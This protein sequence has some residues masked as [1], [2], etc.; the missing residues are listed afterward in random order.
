MTLE[1]IDLEWP[2]EWFN[3]LRPHNV[4]QKIQPN[5][6]VK[7]KKTRIEKRAK[8]TPDQLSRVERE[9]QLRT[10]ALARVLERLAGDNLSGQE[11]AEEYIRRLYRRNCR[12]GTL[13]HNGQILSSFLTFLKNEGK[14]SL[15]EINRQDLEAFVEYDQDRGLKP[16]G[17]GVRLHNVKSFLRFLIEKEIV[18][19]AVLERP[20]TIKLPEPLPRAIDPDDLIELLSVLDDTRNRAMILLL[21]RTGMRI[22]ELLN[23]TVRDVNLHDRKIEIFEASKNRRGRVV[24]F[25]ADAK[26]ALEAWL[27]KRDSM[28]EFIFYGRGRN[29]LTYSAARNLFVLYLEKAE[30]SHMDYTI[31]CLRHTYASELLN[32]GMR[33]ES[34]Q[35]LLGHS[36]IEVTRR[37]ARLTDRTREDEYFKAMSIIERGEIDGHYRL[38]S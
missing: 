3:P 17:V 16:G 38:D 21:L 10:Q 22:G 26:E 28:K 6:K 14:I 34:L 27:K 12:A 37:Y 19:S 5:P 36:S 18:S 9:H 11:Y 25:C 2:F 1:I 20:I 7:P 23:T 8:P 13:R 4:T 24:Y 29:P 33:L 30:L 32:A 31:H 15:K 35:M